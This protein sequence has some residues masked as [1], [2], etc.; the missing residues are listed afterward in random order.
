MAGTVISGREKVRPVIVPEYLE[1]VI[2]G[3][4]MRENRMAAA[5][6]FTVLFRGKGKGRKNERSS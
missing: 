4:R 3:H 5:V 2:K 6:H 1:T